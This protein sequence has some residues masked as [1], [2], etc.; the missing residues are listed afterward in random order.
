[1]YRDTTEHF[2]LQYPANWTISKTSESMLSTLLIKS[3]PEGNDDDFLENIIVMHMKDSKMK[4]MTLDEMANISVKAYLETLAG[5]EVY[6]KENRIIDGL[7]AKYFEAKCNDGK[8]NYYI[9]LTVVKIQDECFITSFAVKNTDLYFEVR[10]TAN[11]SLEILDEARKVLPEGAAEYEGDWGARDSEG[12]IHPDGKGKLT[13]TN[14]DEYQ[15]DFKNGKKDGYGCYTW[16]NLE[17]YQGEWENNLKDGEGEL[18]YFDPKNYW[19]TKTGIWQN[20]QFIKEAPIKQRPSPP[21]DPSV[22]P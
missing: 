20:D 3:P 1:M 19:Q 16:S 21:V 13:Y 6:K 11:H 5:S 8:T 14:G 9:D 7:P 2:G 10:Y 22:G 12:L 18:W 4:N 17:L 15:G